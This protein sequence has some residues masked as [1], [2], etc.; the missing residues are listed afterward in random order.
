MLEINR[1]YV[2]IEGVDWELPDFLKYKT[3]ADLMDWILTLQGVSRL[4][5]QQKVRVERVT[6]EKNPEYFI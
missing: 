4:I 1:E 6:P 5:L 2:I 3:K